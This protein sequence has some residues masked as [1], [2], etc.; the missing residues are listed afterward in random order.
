MVAQAS[1]VRSVEPLSAGQVPPSGRFSFLY[2]M[3]ARPD[4]PAAEVQQ[5]ATDELDTIT[6]ELGEL[7]A[8]TGCRS[9]G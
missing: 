6:G 3:A 1:F 2:Q 9:R 4:Q 5:L 8:D 7:Q